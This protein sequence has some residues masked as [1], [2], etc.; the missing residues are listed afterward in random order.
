[1]DLTLPE[2]IL[3]AVLDSLGI[4]DQFG[5]AE[6]TILID[7]LTDGGATATLDLW[8]D[9]TKLRGLYLQVFQSPIYQMF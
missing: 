8:E 9:D 5:P 1:M 6:R 3:D 2:E 7:Y 4:A